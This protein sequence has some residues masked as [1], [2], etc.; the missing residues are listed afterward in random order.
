MPP[1]PYYPAPLTPTADTVWTV[2][3]TGTVTWYVSPR[4]C[5]SVA[6]ILSYFVTRDAS[7][8][9][10]DAP[11][12]MWVDLYETASDGSAVWVVTLA[13]NFSA[14]AGSVSFVVPDVAPGSYF[15]VC[16]LFALRPTRT[17]LLTNLTLKWELGAKALLIST[18][19][20]HR[21]E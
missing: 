14:Q 21:T 12:I 3:Q 13:Q 2:G 1:P 4:F 11:E 9:P 10:A 6:C 20:V 15:V 8:V 16:K 7:L 5:V 19:L 17:S 18:L